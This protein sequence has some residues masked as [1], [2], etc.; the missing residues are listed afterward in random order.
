MPVLQYI[1][2]NCNKN[3]EELV[4][5][6]DEEVLC[7]VCKNRAER[8]WGGKMFTTPVFSSKNSRANC[9]PCG[10]FKYH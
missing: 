4:K 5:K 10:G 9:S 8:V 1:C 7:P 3:F 2:K 6:H